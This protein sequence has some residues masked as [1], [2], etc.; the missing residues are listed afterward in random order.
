M[1]V[2]RDGTG[3][4]ATP[5]NS[6]L[7]YFAGKRTFGISGLQRLGQKGNFTIRNN[8]R[9]LELHERRKSRPNRSD[10]DRRLRL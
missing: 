5:A 10:I 9:S 3:S 4:A 6:V 2:K 1:H 8:E 7:I